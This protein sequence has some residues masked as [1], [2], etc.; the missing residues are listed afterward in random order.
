MS[1]AVN[2]NAI[3]SDAGDATEPV[4][5]RP[6]LVHTTSD[7]SDQTDDVR[8]SITS[9]TSP[10]S[11]TSTTSTTNTTP[12]LPDADS[13]TSTSTGSKV[14]LETR[15]LWSK[16]PS[17]AVRPILE[18]IR[19][20]H[21]LA[22]TPLSLLFARQTLGLPWGLPVPTSEEIQ[23]AWFVSEI[24]R[25]V[26]VQE[27][28]AQDAMRNVQD[29][30]LR[31]SAWTIAL[32]RW[33]ERMRALA[34]LGRSWYEAVRCQSSWEDVL[35]HWS[36]ASSSPVPVL[37]GDAYTQAITTLEQT[38]I[39]CLNT[40][41]AQQQHP[42]SVHN[43]SLLLGRTPLCHVHLTSC[44]L[45]L[46]STNVLSVYTTTT[47]GKRHNLCIG[48]RTHTLRTP[49]LQALG[50]IVPRTWSVTDVNRY[51]D[52]HVVFRA[53]VERGMGTEQSVT[54]AVVHDLWLHL[55]T[56]QWTIR[57]E[58]QAG[59][60][61][62]LHE[63]YRTLVAQQQAE[64]EA[65][66]AMEASAVQERAQRD[67]ND[68]SQ[69]EADRRVKQVL[70]PGWARGAIHHDEDA[71]GKKRAE[72][73]DPDWAVPCAVARYRIS[74]P[75]SVQL[76]PLAPLSPLEPLESEPSV[77]ALPT[78]TNPAP[79]PSSDQGASSM[80]QAQVDADEAMARRLNWELNGWD[81]GSSATPADG[82]M[83]DSIAIDLD[84]VGSDC[85]VYDDDDDDSQ[86]QDFPLTWGDT[87]TENDEHQVLCSALERYCAEVLDRGTSFFF[88]PL[89][90]H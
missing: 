64:H 87:W 86:L 15:T 39:A 10:T 44:S 67:P 59:R 76:A 38:C 18:R 74:F 21:F 34:G 81:Q 52:R 75:S 49:L 5:K 53:Y 4:T 47:E 45:C 77:T 23:H 20:E 72:P 66:A 24:V 46:Q 69:A 26:G 42:S 8:T 19:P 1:R 28:Q 3:M 36:L 13:P 22:G 14:S 60:K 29:V 54:T 63:S 61:S 84:Q 12:P 30:L 25:A 55:Y 58:R 73:L 43:V 88:L 33:A 79:V 78:N 65:H 56:A 37:G 50:P 71:K 83:D 68:A 48:C 31:R 6:K 62:E 51:W 16:L 17:N 2:V 9:A 82:W 70:G 35:V 85:E 40:P 27:D 89:L 90:R 57:A 7:G 32:S 11:T 41:P 80:H